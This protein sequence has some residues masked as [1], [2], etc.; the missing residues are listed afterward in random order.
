MCMKGFLA[1]VAK[2]IIEIIADYRTFW[3]RI[4][5]T[6]QEYTFILPMI[7][8]NNKIVSFQQWANQS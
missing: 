8:K 7:L 5:G 1:P 4:H 3:G 6:F 2:E